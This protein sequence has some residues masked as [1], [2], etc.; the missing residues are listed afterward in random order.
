MH[1]GARAGTS[2]S[3]SMRAAARILPGLVAVCSLLMLP[4]SAQAACSG[5]DATISASNV[6]AAEEALLCLVN[7]FRASEGRAALGVDP[8]L[9]TAAREHSDDMVARQY[10]SHA[11]FPNRV[12]EAG[13]PSNASVAENIVYGRPATP[14]SLFE[15][16]RNS[17]LHRENM[18]ASD[19]VATGIGVTAGTPEPSSSGA[20]ATQLFGD[21]FTSVDCDRLARAVDNNRDKIR[22]LRDKLEDARKKDRAEIRRKLRKVRRKLRNAREALADCQ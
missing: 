1:R 19:F 14:R 21:R 5:E 7:E 4:G 17:T 18:L 22:R 10:F 2:I 3:A 8:V 6:V 11:G 15:S 16:W 13:Y 12:F 9:R 20:T